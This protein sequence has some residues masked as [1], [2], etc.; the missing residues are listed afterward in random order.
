[1][2]DEARIRRIAERARAS[3]T[4]TLEREVKDH[5][6]G[7]LTI[8]DVRVTG[9]LQHVTV[10]Y[11]ILGDELERKRTRR[12]LNSARGLF[13]SRMGQALGLRLTPTLQFM[14]DHLGESAASL[15]EAL[16]RARLRDAEI[17]RAAQGAKYA[18]EADPY[19]RDEDKAEDSD[20]SLAKNELN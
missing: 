3:I 11:T 6:L 18:G 9:D 15:E 19:K 20:G 10:F 12:A 5:R 14:E 17:S 1:M 16:Q 8:T 7:F 2:A 4:Q 13:R